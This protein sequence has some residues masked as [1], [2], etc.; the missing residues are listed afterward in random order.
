MSCDDFCELWKHEALEDGIEGDQGYAEQ[1]LTKEPILKVTKLTGYR[2][3]ERR[4]I[5]RQN[6]LV[7]TTL[8]Q[9]EIAPVT[10][11]H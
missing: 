2:Q 7:R 8:S 3:W 11:L 4:V 10:S 6:R 1:W 9:K 5:R